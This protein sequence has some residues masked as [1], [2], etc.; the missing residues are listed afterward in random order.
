MT[1]AVLVLLVFKGPKL[2]VDFA[3]GTMVHI[4][5]TQQVTI[6]EIRR[7]LTR[8]GLEGIVQDFGGSGSGEFLIRLEV[9]V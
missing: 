2:G 7:A 9:S 3:G 5:F 1:L 4:K 8:S 6:G